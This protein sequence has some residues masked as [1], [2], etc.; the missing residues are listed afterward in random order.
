MR[1]DMPGGQTRIRSRSSV[2]AA[3]PRPERAFERT[4]APGTLLETENGWRPIESLRSGMRV[5]TLNGM[6]P[7]AALCRQPPDRSRV[8]WHVPAGNLGNCSDMRLNAG[9]HVAVMDPACTSLF[10][11]RLVLIPAPTTT[12]FCGVRT[13]TGFSLR[14]G[15]ALCFEEEQIV[16][17]HTGMLLYVPGP[18][19]DSSHRVLSYR[20]SRKLLALLCAKR[21]G[22]RDGQRTDTGAAQAVAYPGRGSQSPLCGNLYE[23]TSARKV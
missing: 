16:F 18:K 22:D 14:G 6:V 23:A 11:A 1:Q 2:L 17:A 3:P 21:T 19:P 8:H 4:F 13:I 15:I 20:E 10:D 5:R 9:Q 7:I 12:G